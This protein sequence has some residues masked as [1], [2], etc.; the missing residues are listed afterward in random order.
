ME[1]LGDIHL[2]VNNA[3]ALVIEDALEASQESFDLYVLFK[4][5]N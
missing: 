2:L 4:N 3:A 5:A 1:E